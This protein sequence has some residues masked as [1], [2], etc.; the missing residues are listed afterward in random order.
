MRRTYFTCTV[1][2]CSNIHYAKGLCNKHYL[3]V[4]H[5]GYPKEGVHHGKSYD[6]VYRIW[7]NMRRRCLD[8]KAIS[9]PNYGGRGIAVCP[10]WRYS[11]E[12]FYEDMGDPPV[13]YQI[14]RINNDG[15]Y[16][17]ENCR[18]A[19]PTE[20]IRNSR[21]VKLSMEE[22]R[23]IRSASGV[24]IKELAEAFKVSSRTIRNVRNELTWRESCAS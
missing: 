7:M 3:A 23:R 22:A 20:N 13:G 2:G 17:K 9:Y 18:W 10:E 15:P 21:W 12:A 8:P 16:C 5:H 6:R 1:E 24:S 19:T 11:F 4:K 14:D